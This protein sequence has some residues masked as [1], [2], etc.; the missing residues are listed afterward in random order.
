MIRVTAAIA[1]L[2]LLCAGP[3]LGQ[4]I[5]V[6]GDW[7]VD[8]TLPLGEQSFNMFLV[9]KDNTLSGHMVN[10]LGEFEVKGSVNRDQIKLE[11]TYPDG[12]HQLAITFNG[13]FDRNSMTGIAKVGDIG[14]GAMSAQRR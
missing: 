1:A 8:L 13:K 5:K 11:W 6:D 10:E 7:F 12:G 14:E 4:T 3:V 2:F 9:Q